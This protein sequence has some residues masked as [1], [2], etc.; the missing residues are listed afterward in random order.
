MAQPRSFVGGHL[1]ATVVGLVA[2]TAWRSFGGAPEIWMSAAVGAAL[3]AMMATRTIQSPAGANPLVVFAEQADWSFL[4]APVVPGLFVLF[5]V[6]LLANNLPPP[7]GA[8][9]WPRFARFPWQAR[10]LR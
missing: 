3:A 10:F 7:W 4:L 2:V 9:P 5:L 1:L 8:A 6:A